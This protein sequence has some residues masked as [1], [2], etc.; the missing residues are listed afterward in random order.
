MANEHDKSDMPWQVRAVTFFGVPSA[1]ALYLVYILA[2]TVVSKLDRQADIIS[3]QSTRNGDIIKL[4]ESENQVQRINME[5]VIRILRAN[6]VNSSA[7]NL[8]RDRCNGWE[9]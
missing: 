6:C 1:I 7:T 8:E 3:Q 5:L 2:G 9:F 4:I